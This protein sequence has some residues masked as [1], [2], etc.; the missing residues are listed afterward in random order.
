MELT[1]P[2]NLPGDD[3]SLLYEWLGSFWTRL[4]DDTEF[5]KRVQEANGILS[6]QLYQ[7][8]LDSYN[9]SNRINVPVYKRTRWQYLTLK[10]TDRNKGRAALIKLGDTPTPVIGP[11]TGPEFVRGM[12]F[13]IG[14]SATYSNVTIYPLPT[15]LS[16]ITIA[17]SDN[18]VNPTVILVRN[19]DFVVKN[20]SLYFMNGTDPFAAGKFSTYDGHEADGTVVR[21]IL[22]WACDANYDKT[23]VN[24]NVGYVLEQPSASDESTKRMLN[25][26]WDVAA[27][28]ATIANTKS[29]IAAIAG[30]SAIIDSQEIVEVILT[31]TDKKQVITDKNVYTFL[32]IVALLPTVVVGATF[33]RGDF[34][35]DTVKFFGDLNPNT[36][37]SSTNKGGVITNDIS[38]LFLSKSLFRAKLT[39]GVGAA[40]ELSNIVCQGVDTNGNPKLSF[41]VYGYPDDVT[42]LWEDIWA[43]CETNGISSETC[44]EPYLDDIL[45]PVEGYIYGRVSPLTYFMENMLKAN[46]AIIYVTSTRLG[47]FG[48]RNLGKLRDLRQVLPAHAYVFIIEREDIS[49]DAFNL[50]GCTDVI[51]AECFSQSVSESAYCETSSRDVLTYHEARLKTRWVPSCR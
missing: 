17:I 48:K 35:T 4:C 24:D 10:E 1:V 38:G 22:L 7:E 41:T 44:F 36:F 27:G 16:D 26:M 32:P 20:N 5:A 46:A 2:L 33:Y 13:Q 29:A 18:I 34:L 42:A 21:Q 8:Y 51:D 40:W 37:L 50:A 23:Y 6:A 45:V 9:L 12:I 30:E 25:G 19:I 43:Y 3:A 47:D 28:S 15:G 14:G 49:D 39:Y 31:T 11:Q